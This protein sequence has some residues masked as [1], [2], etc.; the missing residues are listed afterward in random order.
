MSHLPLRTPG[1][2]ANAEMGLIH[3]LF[4]VSWKNIYVQSMNRHYILLCLELFLVM[5]LAANVHI[6]SN[7][8]VENGCWTEN[9]TY[10]PVPAVG[11]LSYFN[12]RLPFVYGPP[13]TYTHSLMQEAFNSSGKWSI[14]NVRILALQSTLR[15]A[16]LYLSMRCI[17]S[18]KKV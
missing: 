6:H 3:Q 15:F 1:L 9:R 14:V 16:S 17:L 2:P 10:F 5:W 11:I 7:A 18:N 4:V 8:G 13:N 12:I